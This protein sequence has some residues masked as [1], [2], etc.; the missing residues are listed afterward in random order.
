MEIVVKEKLL[1]LTLLHLV[2]ASAFAAPPERTFSANSPIEASVSLLPLSGNVGRETPFYSNYRPQLRAPND[3]SGV[4]CAVDL[5]SPEAKVEPGETAPAVLRCLD[6]L[7]VS[8][9]PAT[10]GMYEGGRKVGVATIS[11]QP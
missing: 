6:S 9:L 5:G 7:V 11:V 1:A 2:A 3:E 4:T 8:R 10:L